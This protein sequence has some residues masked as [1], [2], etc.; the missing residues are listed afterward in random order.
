MKGS[1][2]GVAVVTALLLTALSVTLVTGIFWQQQI[3]VRRMEGQRQ[4]LQAQWLARAALDAARLSL[5]DDTAHSS[6][7]VLDG[8]WSTPLLEA[9]EQG[10]RLAQQVADAQGL[11]NLRNLAGAGG[12]DLFQVT[13]FARLLSALRLEAAL[14]Y[15]IAEALAADQKGPVIQ[16]LD[17]L[18][19]VRGLN[20][21]VLERLRGF[22]VILPA[23]TAINVNTA[24]PEVLTSVVNFSLNDARLLAERRRQ[25]HFKGPGDFAFRL[26]DRETLEGINYGVTSD[27]FLVHGTLT[28]GAAKLQ[29]EA[30]IRRSGGAALVWV[31]YD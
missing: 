23:Q 24:P 28:Q 4:R 6:V 30:L 17:D 8:A 16:Q 27:Y 20:D 10:G 9:T 26:N 11:F 29:M 18:R 5:L 7:T 3:L 13:A 12:I 22:V 1:Q 19:G 2:R 14:A 31:R 25:A 15:S 21:E